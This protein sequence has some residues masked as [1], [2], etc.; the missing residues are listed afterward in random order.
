MRFSFIIF[1]FVFLL[2]NSLYSQDNFKEKKFR[3]VSIEELQMDSCDFYSGADAMVLFNVANL[4]ID[5]E[6]VK[7][8]VYHLYVH[9]RIKIFS[10]SGKSFASGKIKFIKSKAKRFSDN[11]RKFKAYTY[12][13]VEGKVEETKI[14]KKD[15]FINDISDYSAEMSFAMPN[16]Q[17]G[18]VIDLKYEIISTNIGNLKTWFFQDVIPVKISK[19]SYRFPNFLK[20]KINTYGNFYSLKSKKDYHTLNINNHTFDAYGKEISM[21]NILPLEKEKYMGSLLGSLSRLEFN[22]EYID[23]YYGFKYNNSTYEKM[24]KNLLGDSMFGG[25]MKKGGFAKVW[26]KELKG[27]SQIEKAEFILKKI[28]NN[29]AWNNIFSIYSGVSGKKLMK[30]G[31]GNTGEINWALI[32]ALKYFDIETYPV[33][34]K[35]KKYG[36]PN[37]AFCNIFDYDYLV[38]LVVI[39]NKEYFCDATSDFPFGIIREQCI[40]DKGFVVDENYRWI[41]MTKNADFKQSAIYTFKIKGNYIF[42]DILVQLKQYA[43]FEAYGKYNNEKLKNELKKQFSDYEIEKIEF[44]TINNSDIFKYSISLKKEIEDDEIIVLEPFIK[45][46]FDINP[47]KK[48]ERISNVDFKYNITLNYMFNLELPDGYTIEL[49]SNVRIENEDK[50]LKYQYMATN[51]GDKVVVMMKYKSAKTVFSPQEYTVLKT[52]FEKMTTTNKQVV[53]LKKLK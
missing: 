2:Y 6:N 8:V 28:Q 53:L 15:K 29:T 31:E 14:G 26:E 22:L 40:N 39:D 4:Y 52:F 33:I 18:S 13:L 41:D 50:T 45:P 11:I 51:G 16:V 32:S 10:N 34:I 43:A 9:K 42:S 5:Y 12:N 35:R 3:D 17:K 37:P 19:I 46:Y 25:R 21:S 36:I 23:P 49:P 44:D 47:F 48:E 38:A 7:G 1:F 27:K 30:K 24:N 20:Y